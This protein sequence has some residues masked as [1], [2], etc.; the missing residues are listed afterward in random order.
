VGFCLHIY[1]D[2]YTTAFDL[3]SSILPFTTFLFTTFLVAYRTFSHPM[4]SVHIYASAR[5]G[6]QRIDGVNKLKTRQSVSL[7]LS[8]G[9]VYTM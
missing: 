8:S 2:A 6:L 7:K 4:D 5:R 9:C 1:S 3:N